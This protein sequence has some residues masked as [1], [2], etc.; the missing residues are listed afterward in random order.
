[1]IPDSSI[2]QALSADGSLV[3]LQPSLAMREGFLG[4]LVL[5]EVRLA[6][7]GDDGSGAG[8]L[9]EW[10]AD[11]PPV[12]GGVIDP[13]A[14]VSDRQFVVAGGSLVGEVGTGDVYEFEREG[15]EYALKAYVDRP[16]PMQLAQMLETAAQR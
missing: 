10:L 15:G 12:K 7:P 8:Y 11:R 16:S 3:L 13:E 6:F 1:M 5:H 2:E 14:R 4:K 9:M